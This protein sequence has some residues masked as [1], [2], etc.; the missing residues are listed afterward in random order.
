MKLALKIPLI[1]I[2][3]FALMA[4]LMAASGICPPRGP[5]PSP[6]WCGEANGNAGSGGFTPKVTFIVTVP[7]ATPEEDTVYIYSRDFPAAKMT[8]V[9]STTWKAEVLIP[10][11]RD[12]YYGYDRNNVGFETSEDIRPAD[13]QGD[14]FKNRKIRFEPPKSLTQSDT[15]KKWR[16][17]LNEPPNVEIPP[18]T[19]NFSPRASGLN[20]QKGIAVIDY[21][22]NVFYENGETENTVKRIIEDNASYV[23]YSPTWTVDIT[24][25]NITLNKTCS[26]C[27]PEKAIRYEVM[28][29]KSAGLKVIFRNQVWMD[30]PAEVITKKRSDEWWAQYYN[31]RREYLLDI[32]RIAQE[33]GVEAMDIGADYDT[34]SG[35]TTWGNSPDESWKK[36]VEDIR[37]VR[38]V[39]KGKLYYDFNPTGKFADSYS[40]DM[41]KFQPILDEVDFIG[42]SWWKGISDKDNPTLE[43]LEKNAGEQFDNYLKPVYEKTGKPLVLISIAFPSAQGGSTG[44][45]LVNSRAVDVWKPEDDTTNDFKEQAYV[46]EALMKAVADRPWIVGTYTFGYWRHDQQDKGYNIRGKPAEQVLKK[47]YGKTGK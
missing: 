39:Y 5:W 23:E 42:I 14:W 13:V 47:W 25:E 43:E 9:N 17:L 36:W 37:E 44:K 19:T 1:L 34:L 26:Y 4:I 12:V 41:K 45:Y 28:A 7:E 8:R 46:Y 40:I 30:I 27:Y 20:F 18:G 6:P 35:F 16:W 32:A 22:W 29:A 38:K 3:I 15:V 11:Y 33:E 31:T 21:W 2:G 10:P 24:D